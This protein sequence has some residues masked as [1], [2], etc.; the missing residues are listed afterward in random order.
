MVESATQVLEAAR[1]ALGNERE[2]IRQTLDA[3]RATLSELSDEAE[4][5][6]NIDQLLGRALAQYTQQLNEALG[7]AQTHI[8][9]MQEHTRPRH[10][11]AASGG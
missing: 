5:L 9:K 4:K 10:R 2:G 1:S 3:A 11:H 8:R 6:N 7:T